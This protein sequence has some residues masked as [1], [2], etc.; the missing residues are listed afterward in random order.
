M[1]KLQHIALC[2]LALACAPAAW[3]A[4][5]KPHSEAQQAYNQ[6]RARCMSGQSQQDRATCLREAGAAL[7]ESKRGGLTTG[8]GSALDRNA[9]ARCD[10]QPAADKAACVARIQGAAAVSGTVESG[11]VI[12]KTETAVPAK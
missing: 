4:G 7:A 2:S 3:S 6:E 8:S 11:G 10:A 9:T 5:N 12:R 1:T